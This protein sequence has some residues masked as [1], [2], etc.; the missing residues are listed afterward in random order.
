MLFWASE[1]VFEAFN[2][3]NNKKKKIFIIMCLIGMISK[4]C[5][6]EVDITYLQKKKNIYITNFSLKYY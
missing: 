6:V 3:Y 5:T 2:N 4:N 1:L